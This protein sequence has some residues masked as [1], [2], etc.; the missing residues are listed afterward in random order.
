MKWKVDSKPKEGNIRYR[1]KFAWL[2]V[3]C[4]IDAEMYYIWLETYKVKECYK[5]ALDNSGFYRYKLQ[6]KLVERIPLFWEG[7]V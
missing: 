4:Y 6:W 7:E 2:P 3:H 1:R 5:K